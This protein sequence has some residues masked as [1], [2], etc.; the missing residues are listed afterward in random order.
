MEIATALA[1]ND[2]TVIV[3]KSTVPVGTGREVT[4]IIRKNRPEADFDVAS[5][6]EFLREGSAIEDFM[7]PDRVIAA[8]G[9]SVAGKRIGVLGVTFKPNTDDMRD[10]PSLDIILALS[11][12]GAIV[13]PM[14]RR[15]GMRRRRRCCPVWNGR[16]MPMAR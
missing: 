16:T 10:A 11:E 1:P 13:P 6:P 4:R 12:A 8:C 2:Y 15:V 14:T 9:G 3:T 7:R 5:N